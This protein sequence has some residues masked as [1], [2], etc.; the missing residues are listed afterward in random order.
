[1][2][3]SFVAY[4]PM[5]TG[6]VRVAACDFDG[7]AWTEVVTGAGPGGGPHVKVTAL[8]AVGNRLG[9]LASFLA[10]DASFT[11]G[12]WVACGDVNGDGKAA[13]VVGADRGGAPLV[14]VFSLTGGGISEVASFLGF[15]AGF[16][17]GVRVATGNVDGSDRASI[18]VAPG[19]GGGPQ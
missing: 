11:G 12:V 9:D 17:G 6:G 19:P 15:G 8:D 4:D 10:F 13:V 3:T 1:L 5:F 14:R 7:D 18:I 2:A 16:T